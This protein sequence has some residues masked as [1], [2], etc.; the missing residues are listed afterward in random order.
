MNWSM[1]PQKLSPIFCHF[2]TAECL[3][4]GA[5]QLKEDVKNLHHMSEITPKQR[6]FFSQRIK[7]YKMNLIRK[8]LQTLNI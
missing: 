2:L 6:G 7:D 4:C 3:H 8:P 1:I 5:K